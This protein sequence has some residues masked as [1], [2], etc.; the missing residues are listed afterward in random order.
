MQSLSQLLTLSS[1]IYKSRT[2]V[3]SGD[4]SG[5]M[6]GYNVLRAGRSFLLG[7]DLFCPFDRRKLKHNIV[8][9]GSN[10]PYFTQE[11]YGGLVGSI[12]FKR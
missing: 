2:F 1:I 12:L 6:D 9:S 10:I 3:C 5:G 8:H 4:K 7:L 11:M